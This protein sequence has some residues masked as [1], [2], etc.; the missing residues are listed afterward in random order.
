MSV[1]GSDSTIDVPSTAAPT[2]DI[3][4]ARES[5]VATEKQPAVEN[6][7]DTDAFSVALSPE[8]DPKNMTKLRKWLSVLVISAAALCVTSCSSAVRPSFRKVL[9]IP[10]L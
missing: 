10:H 4:K 5:V 9:S 7:Q 6:V 2:Q 3:E 8:E 1:H